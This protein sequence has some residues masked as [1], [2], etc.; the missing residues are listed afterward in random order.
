MDA[1]TIQGRWL[2]TAEALSMVE[3]IMGKRS[4]STLIRWARAGA[5]R[6]SRTPG[7]Q[8]LYWEP[9][10]RSLPRTEQAA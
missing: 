8:R 1:R 4:P 3:Q 10:I 9:D 2:S 6:V 7:N 5:I